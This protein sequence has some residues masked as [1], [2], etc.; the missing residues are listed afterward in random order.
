MGY[1]SYQIR[2]NGKDV[3]R[4]G[5]YD[6]VKKGCTWDILLESLGTPLGDGKWKTVVAA[7][8]KRAAQPA[9]RAAG[10]VHFQTM[11]KGVSD[12]MSLPASWHQ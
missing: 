1:G 11:L 8:S 4:L 12:K 6:V 5:S 7:T 2:E 10:A 3:V 9:P